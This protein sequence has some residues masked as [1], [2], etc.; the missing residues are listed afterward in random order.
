[1]RSIWVLTTLRALF[2]ALQATSIATLI[3]V[4]YV[5]LKVSIV[6]TH[7]KPLIYL[8]ENERY[9]ESMQAINSFM[10]PLSSTNY[11]VF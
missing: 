8:L 7:N 6:S 5:R 10:S 4:V 2:F 1:M 11:P 9:R 3:P